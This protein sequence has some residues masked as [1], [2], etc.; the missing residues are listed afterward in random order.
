MC[1]GALIKKEGVGGSMLTSGERR[2]ATLGGIGFLE[3]AADGNLR[4]R[5][6]EHG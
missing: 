6:A 4:R 5:T 2:R 1:R 3:S